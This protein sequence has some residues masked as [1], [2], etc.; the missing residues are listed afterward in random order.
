MAR[1][2]KILMNTQ[3]DKAKP[4]E[5]PYHLAD[6]GGLY[7]LVKPNGVKTWQFNYYKPITKKRIYISLNNYPNL[8]LAQVRSKREEFKLA[9]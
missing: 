4:S 7:L 1:T 6:G 5:K 3:V 2:V 8:T 9:M